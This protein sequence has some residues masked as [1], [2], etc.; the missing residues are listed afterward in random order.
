ML[1]QHFRYTNQLWWL[2]EYW[3]LFGNKLQLYCL[4]WALMVLPRC[5]FDTTKMARFFFF[6]IDLVRFWNTN[7]FRWEKLLIPQDERRRC[8]DEV[9][10][11]DSASNLI[12]PNTSRRLMASTQKRETNEN[13]SKR[14]DKDTHTHRK[15]DEWME[16]S[17]PK[18]KS[19]E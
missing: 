12:I 13:K 16:Q 6:C 7:W 11:V 3:M 18:M 8:L 9:G 15:R 2:Q 19:I 1:L 4:K 17:K 5:Y 14:K 10:D